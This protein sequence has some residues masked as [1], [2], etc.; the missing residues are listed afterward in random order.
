MGLGL[1]GEDEIFPEQESEDQ[2]EVL[3]QSWWFPGCEVHFY[4]RI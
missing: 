4:A 3:Q 1:R 2:M